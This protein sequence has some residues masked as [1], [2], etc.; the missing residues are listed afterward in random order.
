MQPERD[1]NKPPPIGAALRTLVE[2]I[3]FLVALVLLVI[4]AVAAVK[5]FAEWVL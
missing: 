2:V 1:R 4:L 3:A 5:R